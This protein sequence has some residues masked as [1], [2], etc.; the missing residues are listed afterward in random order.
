M[1][2]LANQLQSLALKGVALNHELHKR[3]SFL[4]DFTKAASL[5]REEAHAIGMNGYEGLCSVDKIF[6]ESSSLF[7]ET[8]KHTE[9]SMLTKE[10]N[11]ELDRNIGKFVRRMVPYFSLRSTHKCIEW[12]VYR[13]RVHYFNAETLLFAFLPYHTS[14]LYSRLLQLFDR[15][16]LEKRWAIL[17]RNIVPSKSVVLEQCLNDRSFFSKI[18]ENLSKSLKECDLSSPNTPGLLRPAVNVF[19]IYAMEMVQNLKKNI[20]EFLATLMPHLVIGI[21]SS[22]PDYKA[23][24]YMIVTLLSSKITITKEVLDSL[25]ELIADDFRESVLSKECLLTMINLCQRQ[26]NVKELSDSVVRILTESE[27]FFSEIKEFSQ[28][29][30]E[31]FLTLFMLKLVTM[32]SNLNDGDGLLFNLV[33]TFQ[34]SEHGQKL[35]ITALLESVANQNRDNAM[36]KVLLAVH[37]KYPNA[38]M[39]VVSHAGLMKS[40]EQMKKVIE[41]LMAAA[42][43]QD[44]A[45]CS[46][47]SFSLNFDSADEDVRSSSVMTLIQMLK[48]HPEL[49]KS[50]FVQQSV[51]SRLRCET[52]PAVAALFLGLIRDNP[53][54]FRQNLELASETLVSVVLKKRGQIEWDE[55]SQTALEML[56]GDTFAA[57]SEEV[58]D[59]ALFVLQDMIFYDSCV[60]EKNVIKS[61]NTEN[62]I[63][64]KNNWLLSEKWKGGVASIVPVLMKTFIDNPDLLQRFQTASQKVSKVLMSG[65]D[66]GKFVLSSL[67]YKYLVNFAFLKRA[68]GNVDD[69]GPFPTVISIIQEIVVE[70]QCLFLQSVAGINSTSGRGTKENKLDFCSSLL[71]LSSEFHAGKCNISNAIL[72]LLNTLDEFYDNFSLINKDLERQTSYYERQSDLAVAL[73]NS[74]DKK[75]IDINSLYSIVKQ[76]ICDFYVKALPFVNEH[77]NEDIRSNLQNNMRLFLERFFQDGED[78]VQFLAKYWSCITGN[79][80]SS[81]ISLSALQITAAI[82]AGKTKLK[83]NV[84]LSAASPFVPSLLSILNQTNSMLRK[85]ALNCLSVVSK[86]T[87]CKGYP[88]LVKYVCDNS[89]VI[90]DDPDA[91]QHVLKQYFSLKTKTGNKL[92]AS[93]KSTMKDLILHHITANYI[94]LD[95]RAGLLKVL[96]KSPSLDLTNA[97]MADLSD[98]LTKCSGKRIFKHNEVVFIE[99]SLYRIGP[100]I[101]SMP[102]VKNV[103]WK[104]LGCNKPILSETGPNPSP[105][106]LCLR[107]IDKS[108]FNDLD[109]PV[110]QGVIH[111]LIDIASSSKGS[112]DA[113]GKVFKNISL[114]ANLVKCELESL[115]LSDG[116][117]VQKKVRLDES[118]LQDGWKKCI[119]LLEF[120]QEKKKIT[121]VEVLLPSLF[122][123]LEI[124]LDESKSSVISENLEYLRQLILTL[125]LHLLK[126]MQNI[127]KTEKAFGEMIANACKIEL[128]VHCVRSSSSTQ[129]QHHALLLLSEMAEYFPEKVLHN[130]MSIFTFMGS[131]MLRQD[132]SYSLQ[133]ITKTMRV[134]IPVLTSGKGIMANKRNDATLHIIHAFVD[135]LPHIPPHR[136]ILVVHELLDTLGVA[137]YLWVIIVLLADLHVRKPIVADISDNVALDDADSRPSFDNT[138]KICCDICDGEEL[139]IQISSIVKCMDYIL[140]LPFN[141]DGGLSRNSAVKIVEFRSL[142]TLQLRKFYIATLTLLMNIVEQNRGNLSQ[143]LKQSQSD[144]AMDE[145]SSF[146]GILQDL[147]ERVMQM[148][149]K[150]TA[151]KLDDTEFNKFGKAVITKCYGIMRSI[152]VVL[153]LEISLNIFDVLLHKDNLFINCKALELLTE[154]LAAASDSSNDH[155]AD[156]VAKIGKDVSSMILSIVTS[157]QSLTNEQNTLCY[158]ALASIKTAIR[159]FSKLK[160]E[161]FVESMD[162]LCCVIPHMKNIDNFHVGAAVFL[163]LAEM[164]SCLK[165]YCIPHLNKFVPALLQTVCLQ[166]TLDNETMLFSCVTL[167]HRILENLL[168]FSSSYLEKIVDK[169]TALMLLERYSIDQDAETADGDTLSSR[170]GMRLKVIGN[171]ISTKVP[172]RI[173]VTVFTNVLDSDQGKSVTRISPLCTLILKHVQSLKKEVVTQTLPSVSSLL[174]KLL[175]HQPES[176]DIGTVSY[177]E[178]LTTDITVAAM[179]KLPENAFRSFFIGLSDWALTEETDDRVSVYYQLMLKLSGKMKGLFSLFC[180]IVIENA[181][182][183]LKGG[184]ISLKSGLLKLICLTLQSIFYHDNSNILTKERFEMLMQPL[185]DQLENVTDSDKSGNLID[186][187][188]NDVIPLL[189]EIASSVADDTCQKLLNYQILLKSRHV[190]STVRYLSLKAVEEVGKRMGGEYSMLLPE[191]IPFLSELMEDDDEE[192]EAEC[193]AVIRSLEKAVGEP[194][195]K[196][197][198]E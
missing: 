159:G 117:P 104:A 27:N 130:L 123:V 91:I 70:L 51:T 87:A 193:H 102:K 157:N 163:C 65:N 88:E 121:N 139:P 175:E 192:V 7:D 140:T 11:D 71:Q 135:S 19:T 95:A 67:P 43:E 35:L 18:C 66:N 30:V 136:K 53:D 107:A 154:Q 89:A 36:L 131:H 34:L 103:F 133:V 85:C 20:N 60:K 190:S 39:N 198:N 6:E 149:S 143:V 47:L 97:V 40:S 90:S 25:I 94:P 68:L 72:V 46:F 118:E 156:L 191:S 105:Q 76:E 29:N 146:I 137:E 96:R 49:S 110:K 101:L 54:V 63:L 59:L 50:D 129:T 176:S 164:C 153:P 2:S 197:F 116:E 134:V 78:A 174:Y 194:L 185:I 172:S 184:D 100:E 119:L 48:D 77:L 182:G 86:A 148:I 69:S 155:H 98:V 21:K 9:R 114:N 55:T 128:V 183:I 132:D 42:K 144:D 15:S 180:G 52:S 13:F 80:S 165:A 126:R 124:T 158:T 162:N 45:D 38:V 152:N 168:D 196:Y 1:T 161:V 58:S 37:K 178:D 160:P 74:K 10:Q 14:K 8:A 93:V 99:E 125:V 16:F 151:D 138:T 111:K 81:K 4:F 115:C 23:A 169:I 5:D 109:L 166:A 31:R 24:S 145:D 141:V 147:Y 61:L 12:L 83:R 108:F 120:L 32:H 171:I 44:F 17:N 173:L 177:V 142:S 82:I 186:V 112:V 56:I 127:H 188:Q 41:G 92:K 28:F 26:E 179:L 3:P 181:A 22:V 73:K 79:E 84:L 187:V 57:C 189:G 33:Q 170:I 150:V 106:T 62:S 113:I 75:E 122:Q 195:Q 64:K 167:I